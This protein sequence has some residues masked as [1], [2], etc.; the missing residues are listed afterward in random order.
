VT[1]CKVVS[2]GFFESSCYLR[3]QGRRV[4]VCLVVKLRSRD[5]PA[6]IATG[7][8]LDGGIRFPPEEIFPDRLLGG[9]GLDQ[10]GREG[11]HSPPSITEVINGG[12]ISL[13][14]HTS[15]WRGA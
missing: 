9:G 14:P 11:D 3:L 5:S 15:L 13:F 10:M 1:P 8:S 6:Y 4:V 2:T 7:Y 12:D